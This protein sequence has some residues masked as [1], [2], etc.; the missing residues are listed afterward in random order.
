VTRMRTAPS[1]SWK[2]ILK[3]HDSHHLVESKAIDLVLVADGKLGAGS[4]DFLS[5]PIIRV[6]DGGSSSGGGESDNGD[7]HRFLQFAFRRHYFYM[8][9]PYN[10]LFPAEASQFV[11]SADGISLPARE[12]T[13]WHGPEGVAKGG[14]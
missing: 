5:D 10:A 11:Q 7:Y 4:G 3:T 8:E 12:Q 9:L 14:R 2:R 6:P 1:S 13:G